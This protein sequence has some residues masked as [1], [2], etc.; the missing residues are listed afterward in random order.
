VTVE[1]EE[2]LEALLERLRLEKLARNGGFHDP[3]YVI[4]CDYAGAWGWI[5]RPDRRA[6]IGGCSSSHDGWGGD[7]PISDELRKAFDRWQLR[8]ERAPLSDIPKGH[9]GAKGFSWR[10][11]HVDGLR[12]AKRLK[13]ELGPEYVVIYSRPWEDETGLGPINMLITDEGRAVPYVH[14]PR[15]VVKEAPPQLH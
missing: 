2:S 11:F 9:D 8:F 6:F 14:V 5:Y 7:K 15:A 1:I 4:D 3:G 13:R 12:L 10:R